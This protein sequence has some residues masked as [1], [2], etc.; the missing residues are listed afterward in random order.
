MS[1]IEKYYDATGVPVVDTEYKV[2][3]LAAQM[4]SIMVAGVRYAVS[5]EDAASMQVRIEAEGEEEP[6]T[7]LLGE[8]NY[9]ENRISINT[10]IEQQRQRVTL[11]HEMTHAI[12]YEAGF[13]EQDE[14]MIDRVGKVLYQV[15]C[16]N[17]FNFLKEG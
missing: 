1:E 6:H 2:N 5:M 12:F 16:D 10:M 7:T 3:L 9:F 17:D 15:L 11:I 13:E 4:P 14:D 8:C